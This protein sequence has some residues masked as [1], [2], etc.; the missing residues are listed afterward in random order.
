M[1]SVLK[2]NKL[3]LYVYNLA[4]L[5]KKAFKRRINND[6]NESNF[7]FQIKT[8]SDVSRNENGE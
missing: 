4:A 6:S 7:Q 1:R 3:V 5:Y 8:D 2:V